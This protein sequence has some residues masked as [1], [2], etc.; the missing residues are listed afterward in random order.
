MVSAANSGNVRPSISPEQGTGFSRPAVGLLA[1]PANAL[2]LAVEGLVFLVRRIVRIAQIF[3]RRQLVGARLPVANRGIA[4]HRALICAA[5]RAGAASG[6]R[7]GR[8]A[9][10]QGYEGRCRDQS[11]RDFFSSCLSRFRECVYIAPGR[12]FDCCATRFPLPP[13]AQETKHHRIIEGAIALL[14]RRLRRCPTSLH[15]GSRRRRVEMHVAAIVDD[16]IARFSLLFT[17]SRKRIC[18][19]QIG[20][21]DRRLAMAAGNVEHVVRLA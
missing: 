16:T 6:L 2:D 21:T 12:E 17:L 20:G 4:T 9:A 8:G 18:R 19:R 13:H 3:L 11:R 1:A 14:L 5:R 7:D 10:D 15:D